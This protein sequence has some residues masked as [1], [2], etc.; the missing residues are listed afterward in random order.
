[1]VDSN[2]LPTSLQ[3]LEDP[4]KQLHKFEQ[5]IHYYNVASPNILGRFLEKA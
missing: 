3:Q 5:A 4:F 2:E 1:M